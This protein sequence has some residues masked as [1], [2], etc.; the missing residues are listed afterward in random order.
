MSISPNGSVPASETAEGDRLVIHGVSKA[1]G[2]GKD[3]VVVLED[4]NLSIDRGQ[5]VTVIGPSGCGK[6]TLLRIV[7]GLLT[8]DSGEVS[9]FGEGVA[10]AIE[11]K[12]IGFVPQ[13]PA[14]LPWRSVLDNVRLPLQ[15]NKRA[16][17]G[18]RA[19]IDPVDILKAFGLGHVLKRRPAELSGGMQQRVAIARAFVFD[20]PILLMDEPFAAVDELT[21]ESLRY[22]LLSIW[23]SNMKTVVFVTHS[24]PEAIALSDVVVIMSPNPGRI[25]K[26]VPVPLPRPRGDL[27]ETTADFH[28]LER[29][30]RLAIRTGWT[31]R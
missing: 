7:A 10:R 13:S 24:I 9:I 18:D 12:H 17:G 25:Q 4:A 29:E 11:A 26:V 20:P 16:N 14:L 30:V 6:T 31:N 27:L 19:T 5:F 22:E 21:R 8:V 28:E 2:Q 3:R 1:F 15:L 23:Q